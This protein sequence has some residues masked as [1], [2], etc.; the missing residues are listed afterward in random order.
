MSHRSQTAR[1]WALLIL[2]LIAGAVLLPPSTT[3]VHPKAPARLAV[4]PSATPAFDLLQGRPDAPTGQG[5]AVND[6]GSLREAPTLRIQAL[7]ALAKTNLAAAVQVARQILL[8]KR[9]PDEWAIALAIVARSDSSDATRQFL[10]AKAEEMAQYEPWRQNP[11]A[12]FL[13]AFDVFVYTRDVDFTPSLAEMVRDKSNP[14]LAHAAFLTLDRLTQS[15]PQPT[16]RT[17][18]DNPT[19]LEGRPATEAGYFARADVRDESQRNLLTEYLL[20]PNRPLPELEAF[21]GVFPNENFMISHNLL[22]PNPAVPSDEVRNRFNAAAQLVAQ[23]QADARFQRLQ[24]QLS[25]IQSRLSRLLSFA[26]P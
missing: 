25:K 12:G 21:A 11:S 16:L 23:W 17:L 20:A 18:L 5:F 15:D 2:V 24:P 13:E 22:T 1:F 10:R 3:P 8:S 6:D 9:S 26:K 7:D 4:A 19:L 14:A